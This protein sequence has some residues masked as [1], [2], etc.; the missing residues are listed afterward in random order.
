MKPNNLILSFFYFIG[1]AAK[2]VV[3]ARSVTSAAGVVGT[4]HDIWDGTPC[5][6]LLEE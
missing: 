4:A 5:T 1:V 6:R 2:A 3:R